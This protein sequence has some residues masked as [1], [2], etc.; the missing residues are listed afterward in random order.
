MNAY[1]SHTT[2]TIA[3]AQVMSHVSNWFISTK[4]SGPVNGQ[5]QDAN[6]GCFELTRNGIKVDKYHAMT[7]FQNAG[8][9][10]PKF[11]EKEY[12]GRDI[13][14][15]S[16]D[17]CPLNFTKNAMW[18]NESY[19]PFIDYDPEEIRT[20]VRKGKLISGVIDKKSV[21]EGAVSGMYHMT[22]KEFGVRKTFDM[23]F[24]LQQIALEALCSTG[25]TIGTSDFLLARNKLDRVHQIV[26]E[27]IQESRLIS[28][29][30]IRGEL[31]PP[32][33]LTTH[34]FYEQTQIQA[35]KISDEIID[36]ILTSISP[37]SN[38]LFKMMAIGT[39]GKFNNILHIM[40]AI[41]SVLINGTRMKETFTFGRTL[42]YFPRFATDPDAYGFI[43]NNYTTGMISSEYIFSSMN[44][45][46]DLIN[47][48]LSTAKTGYMHRK[49]ICTLQ[50]I[51][52]DNFRRC[53]KD[54]KLI[55]MLYGE[56]GLDPRAVEPVSFDTI[57][58]SDS[59]L[60]KNYTI[61]VSTVFKDSASNLSKLQQIVDEQFQ[62]IKRD[63]DLY[64]MIFS[65]FENM[66]FNKPM[67]TTQMLPINV[68]RILFNIFADDQPAS[69]NTAV[70]VINN[71]KLV[72]TAIDNL[73]YV[74]LNDQQERLNM[75]IPDHIRTA[76]VL[77]S[78]SM[79][80]ELNV[81]VL[82]KL[83]TP[84]VEYVIEQ[85]KV[86]Y[87][88]ALID[89]GSCVGITASQSISEPLTQ[90]MLDSH[91]R[92]VGEGT[93]KSGMTRF[94]EIVSAAPVGKEKS[95][96]MV[97]RVKPE[98][99]RN[100]L[101]VQD[102][103]S[104]LEY[105]TFG[106]FVSSYHI[107][108]EKY[109]ELVYPPYANDIEWIHR[110]EKTHPLI[111]K[112]TDLANWCLWYAI[113][114]KTKVLK[115]MSLEVI[116]EK[117][118][119]IGDKIYTVH[120]DENVS[121]IRLRIYPRAVLFKRGCENDETRAAEIHQIV[122]NK[123]LRGINQISKTAII[124]KMVHKIDEDGTMSRDNGVYAIKTVGTNFAGVATNRMVVPEYINS[125][126]V[127]DTYRMLG[128]EA[129]RYKIMT[130]MK[131]FMEDKATANFRHVLIYSDTM[132]VTGAVTTLEPRG[133]KQSENKNTLLQMGS[134]S[135]I[136]AVTN[137]AMV[138]NVNKVTGIS[139]PIILG[140]IPK[141]GTLYNEVFL[142]SEFMIANTKKVGEVFEDMD[143]L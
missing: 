5:A 137:A 135:Q 42:P 133:L 44:S 81:N 20:V 79:R 124:K 120:T 100:L 136:Q 37:N 65:R 56:D 34:E 62:K 99:E 29:K 36:P 106:R 115:G 138:G 117:L 10:F 114:K 101:R 131:T 9:N 14:S 43:A 72:A 118:R 27:R 13:I 49:S 45:R 54:V 109:G 25:F 57:V 123:Q 130:E 7:L 126:S 105:L 141:I 111:K 97:I 139:A 53:S 17:G 59:E 90:Y 33:D 70:D 15:L 112:P 84:Q 58:L 128:I 140:G 89:Y 95:S 86:S 116:L 38:G 66:I 93:N 51:I 52:V 12:T 30:L 6:S 18:Y 8:P 104:N 113:D 103:A 134:S 31:I 98:I 94:E 4:H 102:V 60:L 121:E 127:D 64:R 39:K 91:H 74:L 26:S 87:S 63:R 11:T 80:A 132:T 122:M 2:A 76:V 96:E 32:I 119:E 82:M 108:Y 40:G 92:S 48:A 35:L 83:S 22:S 61:D 47:K 85:I 129:A 41:G 69:K 75:P 125:S 88:R 19:A 3:E 143:E 21:G 73:A 77:A 16:L 28:E 50:S 107:L 110:Y 23:I 24:S 55:Q 68:R 78:I 1:N 67:S 142:D 71:Y 46:F